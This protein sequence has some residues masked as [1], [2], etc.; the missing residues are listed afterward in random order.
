MKRMTIGASIYFIVALINLMPIYAQVPF[1]QEKAFDLRNF[2][3]RDNPRLRQENPRAYFFAKPPLFKT[4]SDSVKI[5]WRG[6]YASQLAPS[7]DAANA[8][9]VDRFGNIYVTGI[10]T[11]LPYG[12]DCL[13]I[14]YDAAGKEIWAARY[15]GEAEG[16]DWGAAIAVDDSGN[17]YVTG[18]SVGAGTLRDYVT[19]KYNSA[20]VLLWVVRYNGPRNENDEAFA[21][22]IDKTGCVY[23]TGASVSNPNSDYVTVKYNA[24]GVTQWVARYG[25][26]EQLGGAASDLAVDDVGN[27]YVTGVSAAAGTF[28]DYATVKYSSAGIEQ[29]A[30]RYDGGQNAEDWATALAVDRAGNVYVTGRSGIAQWSQTDYATIKYN[31]AGAEQWVARYNGPADDSDYANALAVDAAGNIYVTGGSWGAG[32]F[33]D[34]ATIKYNSAGVQQW[35]DRYDGPISD[36]DV[37]N[38]IVLDGNGNVY[39]TGES[40]KAGSV[41]YAVDDYATIKYNANGIRQ[42]IAR[43]N[44]PGDGYDQANDLT[45]DGSGNVYVTGRSHTAGGW[46]GNYDFATLKYN[47]AGIQQWVARYNGPGNSLDYARDLAVDVAGN[48]YVTGASDGPDTQTD[49]ATI[50]YGAAGEQKWIAR[51]NGTGNE[52]DYAQAVKVDQ[53]GNVYVTGQSEGVGTRRDYVT[54]KYNA[55]GAQLWL[56]RYNAPGNLPDTPVAMEV[57]R[58]GNVYVTGSA[59][60]TSSGVDPDYTTIKY[61]AAG[62][63]QWVARYNGPKNSVDEPVGLAVDGAGNVYVAGYGSSA[64]TSSP[65]PG[66]PSGDYTTIKY[67]AAGVQQWMAQ[68]NGPANSTD[69]PAAVAID[70]FGNVYVTGQSWD[71]ATYYDLATVKYNERGV[72]QWVARYN[73]AENSSD[74]AKGLAVD[75][76]GNAHVIG[77]DNAIIKYDAKGVRQWVVRDDQLGSDDGLSLTGLALDLSGNVYVAASTSYS[78]PQSYY[79]IAKYNANGVKQ[80]IVQ[81]ERAEVGRI[82]VDRNGNVY[83]AGSTSGAFWSI[84]TTI[85]YTQGESILQTP[86]S[87]RLAQNYPNPFN[88]ATTIRYAIPQVGPVTLRVYD[89]LGQEVE[90]IVS[91]EH[92]AGVHEIAWGGEKLSSGVYFYRL[93]A[94]EFTETKKLVLLR[95]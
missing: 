78:Y 37:A 62:V 42:W 34:Y 45:V 21:L 77:G 81:D 25:G 84:F 43:Y 95:R 91:G 10:S 5:G 18:S 82:V 85:K 14:K 56:A 28:T 73:G 8:V 83:A 11:K 79:R 29:W 72:A 22:A 35:I 65:G 86:N 50:K 51:Y 59:Y 74:F 13:T 47:P 66:N 17:V 33:S 9:A 70:K 75:A 57:D 23:V 60:H 26:S 87:Y 49:Y 38:A 20:G 48:V 92:L 53:A 32:A 3:W 52:L 2:L 41:F 16:D 63:E 94:G 67:N 27:V 68:Y 7:W 89:L 61:N 15:D 36:Y 1:Q 69:N 88:Y 54:I 24:A 44:G 64:G 19:L 4:T 40:R 71:P 80:W 58:A 39:V 90:T 6:Q 46:G 76:A 55:N 12:V 31:S 30:A 93:Q